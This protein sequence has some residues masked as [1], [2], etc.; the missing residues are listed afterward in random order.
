MRRTRSAA[1]AAVLA[2]SLSACGGSD[3]GSPPI[4]PQYQPQIVNLTDSF[5]F[6]LTNV[7][8]G[9]G[10]LTYT[11][12]N[13]GT[14]ASID[15]SSAITAGAV[16]LTLRD[17]ANAV[18]YQGALNG[19]SGSVSSGTGTAGAWTVVVDFTNATGTINFRCQK[20]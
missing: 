8:N 16:T 12:Q 6:Q 10:S 20:Q 11:W 9:D 17:A 1:A 4:Q 7:Q 18:V 14:K 19:V 5:E 2:L 15:R 13:T 3:G